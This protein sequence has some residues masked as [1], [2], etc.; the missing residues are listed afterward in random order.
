MSDDYCEVDFD[1][2]CDDAEPVEFY[3]EKDVQ[4]RKPYPCSECG[5]VIP[6][7]ETHKRKSYRFEGRFGCD[8][9]CQ[10]CQEIAGEFSFTYIGGLLWESFDHEWDNGA[11]LQGCLNR[12]ESAR[13]KA[14][15]R[16]QW[17]KWQDKRARQ[18]QVALE[19]RQAAGA[20]D[21]KP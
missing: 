1:G 2:A 5:T 20:E 13:A 14:L 8:R 7:G 18:R 3:D 16:D 17:Q 15:M 21:W 9:I 6:K 4:G 11:R 10:P 19:K 12:L